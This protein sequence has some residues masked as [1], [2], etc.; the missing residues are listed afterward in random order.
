[1]SAAA[2]PA[3]TVLVGTNSRRAAAFGILALGFLGMGWRRGGVH[4]PFCSGFPN[5]ARTKRRAGRRADEK[6]TAFLEL[7]AAIHARSEL[8]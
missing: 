1:M 5:S 7:E 4:I 2:Y 3:G 6:L 8:S